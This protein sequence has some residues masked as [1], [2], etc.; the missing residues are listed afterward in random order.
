LLRSL[1]KYSLNPLIIHPIITTVFLIQIFL[2]I[3]L[4]LTTSMQG[5]QD[6]LCP[7]LQMSRHIHKRTKEKSSSRL[8]YA[9]RDSPLKRYLSK[10]W[11]SISE[12]WQNLKTLVLYL[13]KPC[14]SS[15]RNFLFD[16]IPTLV[17]FLVEG[18][19]N[20]NVHITHKWSPTKMHI[21]TETFHKMIKCLQ[22]SEQY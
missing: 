11:S 15:H 17:I 7:I 12:A 5:G 19:W 18:F 4:V 8:H 6:S 2:Y 1:K 14:Y 16:H 22:H 10:V 21:L 9:A 20:K 3:P 13:P